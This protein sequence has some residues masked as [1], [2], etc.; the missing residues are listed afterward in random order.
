MTA[1]ETRIDTLVIIQ[2][3]RDRGAEMYDSREAVR[4]EIARGFDNDAERMEYEASEEFLTAEL[5]ANWERVRAA[6]ANAR[7]AGHRFALDS[8]CLVLP[9]GKKVF[10]R[11][12]VQ[13]AA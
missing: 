10:G 4:A 6:V 3:M 9:N 12:P 11:R 13:R 7:L 5:S 2:N 1:A 8:G